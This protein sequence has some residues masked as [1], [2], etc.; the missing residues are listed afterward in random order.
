MFEFQDPP[1]LIPSTRDPITYLPLKITKS[2]PAGPDAHVLPVS[3]PQASP[4][5]L[6]RG[7]G[8]GPQP[9]VRARRHGAVDS[10][11]QIMGDHGR[12]NDGSI[13]TVKLELAQQ[14]QEGSIREGEA[15][16]SIP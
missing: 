6:D 12:A 10:R 11:P 9:Y 14:P 2:K 16:F 7:D 3:E 1:L 5:T 4:R 8:S 13:V 15:L